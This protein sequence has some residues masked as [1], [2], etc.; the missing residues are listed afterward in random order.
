VP[1]KKDGEVI[2][3]E[4]HLAPI[5]DQ[6]GKPV[7]L[8]GVTM[9]VTDRKLVEQSL[10]ESELRYRALV[11]ATPRTFGSRVPAASLAHS[12]GSGGRN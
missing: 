4:S 8:R 10:A 5:L 2:W 3:L 7:G 11:Q 1:E 12:A 9:N 6:N